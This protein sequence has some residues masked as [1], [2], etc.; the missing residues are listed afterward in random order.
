MG[1]IPS[2][3]RCRS[4]AKWLPLSVSQTAHS[5]MNALVEI[6]TRH[7]QEGAAK[8]AWGHLVPGQKS[9]AHSATLPLEQRG[10]PGKRHF[11][12]DRHF[13]QTLLFASVKHGGLS[14]MWHSETEK[15]RAW[16]TR[17]NLYVSG[18]QFIE[19]Y[20]Y[21][22]L[23]LPTV[24]WQCGHVHKGKGGRSVGTLCWQLF[25]PS[26]TTPK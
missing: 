7:Y 10:N 20:Q 21:R 26:K 1:S 6:R 3:P 15:G 8:P 19:I 22:F 5:L 25:F 13:P 14:T 24:P 9:K 11:P 16:K 18:V 2:L 12:S 4:D 23:V 17:W